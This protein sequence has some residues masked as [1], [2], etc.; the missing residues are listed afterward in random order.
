MPDF[1]ITKR[2]TAS[3]AGVLIARIIALVSVFGFNAILARSLSPADFGQFVLIFSLASVSS[4]I[5]CVGL[6]RL[7]VKRLAEATNLSTEA[8]IRIVKAGLKVACLGGCIVGVIAGVLSTLLEPSPS[9]SHLLRAMLFGGIILLRTLHLVIAESARGMHDRL[10]SNL[11][12]SPAGGPLPHL[13]F[14][15]LLLGVPTLRVTLFGVL[16]LYLVAY[17]ATLPMLWFAVRRTTKSL[18]SAPFNS[19][20][21]VRE[22]AVLSVGVPLMFTQTCGL[23]MSQAD[24]WIAGAMVAPAAIALYGA[25]QRMLGLLTIP[26]QIAGTAIVNF[27]PGMAKDEDGRLQSMVGLAANVGGI[28]GTILAI[29][30][31]VFAETILSVVFGESYA[32]AAFFLR[33]LTIGQVVCL[34]TGPCEISLMMAGHEKTTAKVNI[35][36]AITLFLVGGLVTFQFGLN[37]LAITIACVT[38]TQNLANWLLARHLLGIWTHVGATGFQ[39]LHFPGFMRQ[40]HA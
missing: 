11:F 16:A 19:L 23:A 9:S 38:A 31:L 25:A 24:L 5:A 26:L 6:N 18:A 37:G 21:N 40:Q 22:L 35:V 33:V 28:P 15:L 14:V 13:L 39:R 17:L 20:D 30:F 27:V 4:L 2:F 3:A 10:W 8:A 12:G 1:S 7:I 29:G 32:Q 36:A 34:L